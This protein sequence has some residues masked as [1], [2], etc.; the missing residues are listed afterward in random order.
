MIKKKKKKLCHSWND[1]KSYCQN[2]M[3]TNSTS[4]FIFYKL[5]S[6]VHLRWNLYNVK[7]AKWQ[8]SLARQCSFSHVKYTGV[9][10]DHSSFE[11]QAKICLKKVKILLLRF[12]V[13]KELFCFFY[14]HNVYPYC[15]LYNLPS[16][17]RKLYQLGKYVYILPLKQWSHEHN[18]IVVV[19]NWKLYVK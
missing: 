5:S 3:K 1:K 11:S 16:I 19:K 10:S 14:L 18:L 9:N 4:Q 8:K 15:M 7:K 12:V 2:N 13:A 6:N 17:E